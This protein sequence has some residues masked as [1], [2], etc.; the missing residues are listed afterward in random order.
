MIINYDVESLL[1]ILISIY[2]GV[3]AIA[4]NWRE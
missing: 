2:M 4:Y 1:A 3:N